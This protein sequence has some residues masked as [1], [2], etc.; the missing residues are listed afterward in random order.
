MLTLH[1]RPSIH[2]RTCARAH[3]HLRLRA[4]RALPD[5]R[6]L[7]ILAYVRPSQLPYAR[8]VRTYVRTY[9]RT[10]WL[11]SVHVHARA[12]VRMYAYLRP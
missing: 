8:Y 3:M 7:C 1:I 6:T 10:S 9:F 4:Q 12:C 11:S 2:D 5:K